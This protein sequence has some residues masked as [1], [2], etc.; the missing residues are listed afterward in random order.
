[1]N[2][3]ISDPLPARCVLVTGA[4]GF[5]G[6][7][8]TEEL[9]RMGYQTY[10][11]DDL[12]GGYRENIPKGCKFT[13]LD[14]RNRN[15]VE[16][17]MKKIRPEIIFHDA[18]FAT[19]GGSQFT[20]IN[21]TERN[22]NIY[23]NT[24]VA[25]LRHGMKKMVFASSMS[26]YGGQKAPFS[27]D[28]PRMPEDVYAV[29]KAASEHTTE[30]LARVHRFDYTIIRP[31]NVYGERQN[32]SD[33]YR[34]VI[35]IFI[36]RLMQGKPF[37]IYGNGSQQRSFTHIDDYTPYVLKAGLS[38][39]FNGEKF[40]IGPR[41]TI[42]IKALA[43]LVIAEYFGSM[44]ACPKHLLPKYLPDRPLEVRLAYC[45]HKK[46]EKLLGY[47]TTVNIGQGVSRMVAWARSK[48]PQKFAYLKDGLEL[49]SRTTPT[50]WSKKRY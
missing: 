46:A 17:Y 14:L 49:V 36:N 30:L 22:Y 16:R 42:S 35:A 4:A 25:G 41:E 31:H 5:M 44:E 13:R 26:V 15:A 6:S 39:R 34:N 10:A 24:L 23:L 29:A 33:P 27:E 9:V 28:M 48:G 21:S 7:Y 47:R 45:T 32:L 2:T 19:E 20:P 11:V 12:S 3:G 43:E 40:N 8:E 50:T 18:A 37:F 1:M 38:R